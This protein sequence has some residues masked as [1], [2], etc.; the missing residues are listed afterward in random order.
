MSYLTEKIYLVTGHGKRELEE[1]VPGAP[2]ATRSK[3]FIGLDERWQINFQDST[4]VPEIG[5]KE[6][7]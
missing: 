1:I 6:I 2:C 4:H 3:R 7:F 5:V